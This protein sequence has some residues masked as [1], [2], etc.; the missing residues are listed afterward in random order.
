[1]ES[2]G[3]QVSSAGEVWINVR[4]MCITD[5]LRLLFILP[6]NIKSPKLQSPRDDKVGLVYI[7]LSQQYFV[8]ISRESETDTEIG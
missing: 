6:Q 3:M 8:Q 4:Q 1:M 2:S 7:T 5:S